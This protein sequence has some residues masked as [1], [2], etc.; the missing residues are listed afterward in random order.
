MPSEGRSNTRFPQSNA[1]YISIFESIIALDVD[2]AIQIQ[3]YRQTARRIRGIRVLGFNP[4]TAF[5]TI[6]EETIEPLPLYTKVPSADEI[7]VD[8]STSEKLPDYRD[9][10][11]TDDVVAGRK[12][13][14][15]MRLDGRADKTSHQQPTS[16]A[17]PTRR[18]DPRDDLRSSTPNMPNSMRLHRHRNPVE[19]DML[20]I[21]SKLPG[22]GETTVDISPSEQGEML[23]EYS[24]SE[25]GATGKGED[26]SRSQG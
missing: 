14:R 15:K 10:V 13:K 1:N 25:A 8:I 12:R 19:V 23:P 9:A 22:A 20:P 24:M 7:T 2:M 16:L 26:K 3:R 17:S 11:P 21:Y 18:D 6:D 5:P 4:G